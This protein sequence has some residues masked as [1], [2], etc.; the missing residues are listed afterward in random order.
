MP[1]TNQIARRLKALV[2]AE[3]RFERAT[4]D[5]N[6]AIRECYPLGTVMTIR[7][8]RQEFEVEVIRHDPPVWGTR[9]V[10]VRNLKTG[11]CRH[12]CVALHYNQVVRFTTPQPS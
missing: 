3:R 11:A 5:L 10:Y 8:G 2:A 9:C 6:K 1:T 12:V 4:E 7:H